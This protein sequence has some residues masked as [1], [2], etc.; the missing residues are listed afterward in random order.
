MK[1]EA[2]YKPQ[3]ELAVK[4]LE[5]VLLKYEHIDQFRNLIFRLRNLLQD[6][7]MV[8]NGKLDGRTETYGHGENLWTAKER[9]E[10]EHGLENILCTL[11]MEYEQVMRQW[12]IMQENNK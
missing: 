3:L 9:E 8:L 2:D 4:K 1:T 6:G 7:V 5:E 10:V 12:K 11:L